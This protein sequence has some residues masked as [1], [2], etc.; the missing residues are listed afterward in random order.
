MSHSFPDG[1]TVHISWAGALGP[2]SESVTRL[3]HHKLEVGAPEEDY[4]SR[5]A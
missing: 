1:P 3:N 4:I 2:I 5:D